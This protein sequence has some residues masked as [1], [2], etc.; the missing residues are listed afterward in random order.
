MSAVETQDSICNQFPTNITEKYILALMKTQQFPLAL[1][2]T[3]S[4]QC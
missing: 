3:T 2:Q 4:E 1:Q